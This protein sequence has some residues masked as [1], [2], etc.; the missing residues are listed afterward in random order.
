LKT[1]SR[2]SRDRLTFRERYKKEIRWEAKASV[3]ELF[4]LL[5]KERNKSWTIENTAKYFGVSSGLISED[6][7]LARAIHDDQLILQCPSRQKALK[8]LNNG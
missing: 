2:L 4:H 3:I 6:L 5:S 7:K 8:K 1:K